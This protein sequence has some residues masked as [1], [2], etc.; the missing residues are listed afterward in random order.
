MQKCTKGEQI[1]TVLLN[2]MKL[3]VWQHY[4]YNIDFSDQLTKLLLLDC[5]C[6]F[7]VVV[8]TLP[9]IFVSPENFDII[10]VRP[11]TITLI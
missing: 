8:V 9:M 2:L 11:S 10:Q 7:S 4:Y 5:N 6:I 3:F 1:S